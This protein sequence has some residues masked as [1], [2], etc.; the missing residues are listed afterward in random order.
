MEAQPSFRSC[1]D[2]FG[3]HRHPP[4]RTPSRDNLPIL[5]VRTRDISPDGSRG[6]SLSRGERHI[7][8]GQTCRDVPPNREESEARQV[9]TARRS[10]RRASIGGPSPDGAV[11]ARCDIKEVEHPHRRSSITASCTHAKPSSGSRIESVRQLFEVVNVVSN[12]KSSTRAEGGRRQSSGRAGAMPSKL[13]P[14][15]ATEGSCGSPSGRKASRCQRRSSISAALESFEANIASNLENGITTILPAS[16]STGGKAQQHLMTRRRASLTHTNAP[17]SDGFVASSSANHPPTSHTPASRR[18][19]PVSASV[20]T[21]VTSAQIAGLFDGIEAP[22]ELLRI[23]K[24]A[25][26]ATASSKKDCTPAI[27]YGYN[28]ES[29]EEPPAEPRRNHRESEDPLSRSGHH[30]GGILR[31]P[32]RRASVSGGTTCGYER[33]ASSSHQQWQ[34]PTAE[35]FRDAT[36]SLSRSSHHSGS[37]RTRA[38]RTSMSSIGTSNSYTAMSSS[39]QE[40]VADTPEAGGGRAKVRMRRRSSID[41]RYT[42]Q[43]LATEPAP[44]C[45]NDANADV[46]VAGEPDVVGPRTRKSAGRVADRRRRRLANAL[47]SNRSTASEDKSVGS[48][49]TDETQSSHSDK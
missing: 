9:P 7:G 35:G 3:N 36:N 38:R 11:R 46:P 10:Q 15:Y 30:G 1:E 16:C 43:V 40:E 37:G 26:T 44:P 12:L 21:P 31:K 34:E 41:G 2:Y 6:V 32:S 42:S 45:T 18:R 17:V 39:S 28:N 13:D 27:D 19:A 33:P 49:T 25:A 20:A 24:V 23:K 8:M 48:H 5:P 4:V 47:A 14:G 22:T 29:T